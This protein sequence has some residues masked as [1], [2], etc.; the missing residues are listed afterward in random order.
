ME[1]RKVVPNFDIMNI[2][3]FVLVL[4]K[5]GMEMSDCSAVHKKVSYYILQNN[6]L[7]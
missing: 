6:Y 2:N 4:Y 5:G 7:L 3:T 1:S